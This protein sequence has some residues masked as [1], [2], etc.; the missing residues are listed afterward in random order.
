MTAT[1]NYIN[2]KDAVS[3]KSI[4]RQLFQKITVRSPDS[5]KA[6][7]QFIFNRA[8]TTVLV[9]V[10]AFSTSVAMVWERLLVYK[11]EP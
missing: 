5:P 9:V 7:L 8:F 10:N 2:S 11:R 4:Y 3:L 6:E 1:L